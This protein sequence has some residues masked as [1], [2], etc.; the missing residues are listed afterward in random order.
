MRVD[1]GSAALEGDLRIPAGA[2]GLVLFA[3]GSGSSR[4]SPRNRYVADQ[5]DEASLGTLLTDLLTTDEQRVDLRFDI[6]LLAG[7]LVVITD[8]VAQRGEAAGLKIGYFGPAPERGRR[9]LRR[10]NVLSWFTRWCRAADGRIWREP[11]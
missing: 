10:L 1:A 9:W 6:A 3:H 2:L 11:R 4:L 5:F 7:R 8:W